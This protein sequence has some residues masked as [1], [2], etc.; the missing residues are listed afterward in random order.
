MLEIIGSLFGL[1]LVCPALALCGFCRFSRFALCEHLSFHALALGFESQTLC[2]VC[3]C[4]AITFFALESI[5]GQLCFALCLLPLLALLLER[6]LGF[7]QFALSL[8]ALCCLGGFPRSLRL[9]L[10]SSLRFCCFPLDALLLLLP[11]CQRAS[12]FIFQRVEK[13]AGTL[14][15]CV[16]QGGLLFP[17][18]DERLS[19]VV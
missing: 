18:S 6:C 11:F 2:P 12:D 8:L 3:L 5:A 14:A 1:G 19:S 16:D 10:C 17:A 9:L 13:I 7:A 15:L 4:L